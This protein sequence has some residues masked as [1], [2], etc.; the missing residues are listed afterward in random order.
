MAAHLEPEILIVDEVLAVGD[1]EFQQR[2][3][4][5]MEDMEQ[6]SADDRLRLASDAGGGAAVRPGDPHREGQR[7]A[8]RAERRRRG[9]IVQSIG[10][11]SSTRFWPDLDAAP[12]DELVRLRSVSVVDPD[13]AVIDAADLGESVGIEITYTVL[14]TTDRRSS[15]R[16]RSTTRGATS[17]STRSTRARAGWSAVPPGEYASTAWIPGNLLNEGLM[18]VDVGVC[19]IGT[20]K[21]HPHAGS[22]DAVAFHVQDPGEGDSAK[23]RFAGQ[24]HG[25]VRP[26]LEWTTREN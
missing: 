2:C 10:G 11:S 21:L 20:L 9:Q 1:A 12:G 13:G 17:S 23:G 8:R 18:T 5:H 22:N 19:S 26:L 15:R 7:D 6:L 25:V 16:S 3:L 24:L 14:R 4:G